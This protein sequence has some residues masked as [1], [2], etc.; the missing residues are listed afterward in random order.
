MT[1]TPS[2]IRSD[3]RL[4]RV[5]EVRLV[6]DERPR[7]G[8]IAERARRV[9]RAAAERDHRIVVADLGARELRRDAKERVGRLVGDRDAVARPGERAR[10]EKDQVVGAGAEHD[11]L[12]LD[13]RVAR[14][15]VDE[16][17]VA[18][19]RVVRC[20]S[21]SA[22][23]IAPGP[24]GR[25]AAVPGRS[26]R[27]A[28]S[29]AG[30]GSSRRASSSVDGAHGTR[31]SRGGSVLIAAPPPRARAFPRAAASA[32]TIG[33]SAARPPAVSRWTVTGFRNASR[34]S[35]RRP[36]P[37]RRSG[38]RGCP[39]S[40]SRPQRP[41]TSA[42]RRSRPALRT[43]GCKRLGVLAEQRR[44]ARARAPRPRASG[45]VEVAVDGYDAADGRRGRALPVR[46]ARGP[47]C[48]ASAP[49]EASTTTSD[50]PAGRSIATSRETSSFA[51]FTNA[52]PG[53]TILSTRGI[54]SVP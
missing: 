41:A 35:P 47:R 34:P 22:P 32:S 51:S 36:G 39:R 38:G 9:V 4:A 37:S 52:S 27:S 40:R 18:A 28:R 26:R 7:G 12:G 10:A 1:T 21:A 14:D 29:G 48:A 49:S 50:G 17:P 53:P 11:V 42:R 6:D 3:G 54:G 24:G 19:V 23:A 2:S 44:G 25:G 43:R 5:L 16:L 46:R 30:R 13:A 8:E 45:R 15:R 31:R 33:R 20:T